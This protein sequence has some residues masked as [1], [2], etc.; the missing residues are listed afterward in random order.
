MLISEQMAT[1]MLNEAE[2]VL[3][4]GGRPCVFIFNGQIYFS[5]GEKR[6]STEDFFSSVGMNVLITADE[7]KNLID[8]GDAAEKLI[9]MFKGDE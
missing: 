3:D 4:A 1:K 9:E 5:R 6:I 2:S 7:F 8:S